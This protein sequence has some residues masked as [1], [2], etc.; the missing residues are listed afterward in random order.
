MPSTYT[1][2]AT[3]TVVSAQPSYTFTSIS[4]TYTDLVYV[5]NNVTSGTNMFVQFNGDTSTTYSSTQLYGSGSGNAAST[6][7]SNSS[8]CLGGVL[9]DNGTVKGNI[10]NYSNT[11]TYKTLISRG[12]SASWYLD[13]VVSL[14]RSTAAINSIKFYKD[15][16]SNFAVGTTFTLY[17]ILAA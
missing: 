16:A 13:A 3:H 12:G 14:W 17:G 10:Q 11:S 8:Y 1:P 6:R 9:G 5:I 15:D 7:S 4:S 2:I